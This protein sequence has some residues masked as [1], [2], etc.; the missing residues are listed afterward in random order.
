MRVM[1]R[2][3]RRMMRGARGFR[4]RGAYHLKISGYFLIHRTRR[5]Y[6]LHICEARDAPLRMPSNLTTFRAHRDIDLFLCA[7]FAY[8]RNRSPT[9]PTSLLITALLLRQLKIPV[10]LKSLFTHILPSTAPFSRSSLFTKQRHIFEVEHLEK[11]QLPSIYPILHHVRF[12][13]VDLRRVHSPWLVHRK[14]HRRPS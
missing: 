12:R 13:P 3:G 8:C 4:R 14:F 7:P 6:T 11:S 5:T 10:R 1:D 2:W 9:T